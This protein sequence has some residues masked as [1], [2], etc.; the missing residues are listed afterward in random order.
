M[1]SVSSLEDLSPQEAHRLALAIQDPEF[2]SLLSEYASTLGDPEN[3]RLYEEELKASDPSI[4]SFLRPSPG[5]VIRAKH[6]ISAS[7]DPSGEKIF[8]NV[9]SDSQI[10]GPSFSGRCWRIPYSTS[11]GRKDLSGDGDGKLCLVMDVIVHPDTLKMAEK[12]GKFKTLLKETASEAVEAFDPLIKIDRNSI[13]LPKMAFKGQIHPTVI[14]K[15]Q[16]KF[17]PSYVIKYSDDFQDT[18]IREPSIK[19]SH[20]KVEI[21]LAGFN[22]ASTVEL[23][24]NERNLTLSTKENAPK[25]FNL[26][27]A[28]PYAV[29]EE[30]G[31]AKFDKITSKLLVTLP[32]LKTKVD[33]LISTDSG[34]EAD[35]PD[36]VGNLDDVIDDAIVPEVEP[37]LCKPNY[38]IQCTEDILT[39]TLDV[40]NVDPKSVIQTSINRG[41][42]L[43]FISVGSGMYPYHYGFTV[44]FT[45]SEDVAGELEGLEVD[46]WDNNVTI[47]IPLKESFI[48]YLIGIHEKDLIMDNNNPALSILRRNSSSK[49]FF[50][51]LVSRERARMIHHILAL[52]LA[53]FVVFITIIIDIRF[54]ERFESKLFYNI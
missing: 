39:I 22:S 50:F 6:S 16:T 20:L 23:D 41:V 9:C 15:R 25:E 38:A 5:F 14:R 34:I 2:R 43:K 21:D 33:R 28:L 49:V 31:K 13:R 47:I 10:G 52:G 11:K 30:E 46:V 7:D 26:Q 53:L 17:E 8:I 42:S 36:E 27:V 35:Y 19:P 45:S 40:K 51:F 48:D 37:A 29:D 1:A 44:A 54:N 12:N 18:F 32:V 3:Q 4:Q 24:V